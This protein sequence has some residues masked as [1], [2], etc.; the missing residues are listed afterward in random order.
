MLICITQLVQGRLAELVFNLDEVGISESDDQKTKIVIVPISVSEHTMHHKVNGNLTHVSVIACIL[1]AKG[2]LTPYIVTSQD[3]IHVPEQSKKH[4]GRFGTDLI[5]KA[6]TKPYIN[7]EIF[8]EY[9]R[10]VLLPT[11]NDLCSLEEFAD[12][13]AILLMD[14][15]PNQV[16]EEILSLLRDTGVRIIIWAPHTTNIF[17]KLEICLFGVLKRGGQDKFPFDGDRAKTG[18]LPMIYRA[19]NQTMIEL[20]S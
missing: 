1:A 4:G 14:H 13:E 2:G 6:R 15:C 7:T 8:L 10:T 12:E 17:Q 20:N 11:L 3:Q 5:L 19:F 16:G 9:I 18:F